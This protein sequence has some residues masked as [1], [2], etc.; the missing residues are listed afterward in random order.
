MPPRRWYI[1]V[2]WVLM[3]VTIFAPAAVLAVFMISYVANRGLYWSLAMRLAPWLN[4]VQI[5]LGVLLVLWLS[6]ALPWFASADG[7]PR[8]RPPRQRLLGMRANVW[9]P[10]LFAVGVTAFMFVSDWP[11]DKQPWLAALGV[12]VAIAALTALWLGRRVEQR[13]RRAVARTNLCF[14]CGYDLRATES[15]ACPECGRRIE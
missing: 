11:K 1:V 7:R 14:D 12:A 2:A 9:V 13:L 3:A 5:P 4:T 10:T 8:R 15:E 6:W